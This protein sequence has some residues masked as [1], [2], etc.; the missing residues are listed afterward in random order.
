MDIRPL[1]PDLE[2]ELRMLL[3]AAKIVDF[4]EQNSTA[5]NL[6]NYYKD[7]AYLHT[8]NLYNFFKANTGNDAR[9]T[10]YGYSNASFDLSLYNTWIGPLHDHAHHIKSSRTTPNNVISGS[11]INE[12]IVNFANDIEKIFNDW[13][14]IVTDVTVK[15]LLVDILARANTDALNDLKMIKALYKS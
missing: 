1:L 5:G 10:S 15:Q 12:Q 7:S 14:N 9:I 3:G 4:L 6:I 13:V 11:H 2:Y 8:R